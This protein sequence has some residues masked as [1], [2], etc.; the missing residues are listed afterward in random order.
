MAGFLLLIRVE[1]AER[2]AV[3]FALKSMTTNRWQALNYC[4]GR[5]VLS[6]NMAAR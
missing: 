1:I 3:F 6:E 2:I 4:I 5:L